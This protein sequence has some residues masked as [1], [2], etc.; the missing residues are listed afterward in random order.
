MRERAIIVVEKD[1]SLG[2][3]PSVILDPD[4]QQRNRCRFHTTTY[5]DT[6]SV[7]SFIYVCVSSTVAVSSSVSFND[8]KPLNVTNN[9][10]PF[11]GA[12]A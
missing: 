5:T 7:S 11:F 12:P 3:S 6:D 8:P 10:R 9:D 2:G 1:L 4:T